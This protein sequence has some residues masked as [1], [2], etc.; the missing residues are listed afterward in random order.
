MFFGWLSNIDFVVFSAIYNYV[1]GDLWYGFVFRT[2]EGKVEASR[3]AILLSSAPTS[4]KKT[5]NQETLT[6]LRDLS[7]IIR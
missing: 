4:D 2:S 7:K 1:Q 6:K 3:K 5:K